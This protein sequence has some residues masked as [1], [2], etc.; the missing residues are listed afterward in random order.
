[1]KSS[2]RLDLRKLL[3]DSSF[4]GVGGPTNE[5]P[6]GP[7]LFRRIFCPR[8][9]ALNWVNQAKQHPDWVGTVLILILSTPKILKCFST[10]TPSFV[11]QWY[12]LDLWCVSLHRGNFHSAPCAITCLA[13]SEVYCG[14]AMTILSFKGWSACVSNL[15]WQKHIGH[16]MPWRGQR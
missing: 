12:L 1:M 2:S 3:Y 15:Q 14:Q 9:G 13:F 6:S 5:T 11:F 4:R 7:D 10:C 16:F 8:H